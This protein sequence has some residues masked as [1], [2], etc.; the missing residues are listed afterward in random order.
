MVVESAPEIG[1]FEGK[2]WSYCENVTALAVDFFCYEAYASGV[3]HES[4]A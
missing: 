4:H 1:V 2:T 3:F